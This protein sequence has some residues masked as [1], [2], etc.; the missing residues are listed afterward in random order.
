MICPDAH[1]AFD[2]A[3][4]PDPRRYLDRLRDRCPHVDCAGRGALMRSRVRRVQA[5]LLNQIKEAADVAA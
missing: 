2:C 5:A 4:H 1:A 3:D